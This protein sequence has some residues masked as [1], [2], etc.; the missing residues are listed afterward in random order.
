MTTKGFF[1][2][3]QRFKGMKYLYAI[4]LSRSQTRLS[5]IWDELWMQSLFEGLT[6]LHDLDLHSSDIQ[7][8]LSGMF[9]GLTSLTGLDLGLCRISHI[10]DDAF[11][12]LISLR[13]IYLDG[14]NIARLPN[15]LFHSTAQLET[16]YLQLNIL[17]YFPD[18]L[19]VSTP[20]LTD[21]SLYK[22]EFLT[23]N[24]STFIP[25]KSSLRAIDISENP[26]QC[27]CRDKWI[28][29]WLRESNVIQGEK[30]TC[31]LA[32]EN[33]FR[34]LSLLTIDPKELCET[35]ISLYWSIPFIFIA[36]LITIAIVH[37]NRWLLKY[38]MFLL[39][40]AVLGYKEMQDA[41]SHN[42]YKYDLNVMFA[43]E[44]K[45]WGRDFLVPA[46]QERLPHLRR[47]ALGDDGLM[48]GMYYLEAV[49]YTIDN[50]FKTILL[51]SMAAIHDNMFMMKFRLA[52]DH[53]TDTQVKNTVLIFLED[54]PKEKRPYRVEVYLSENM[55]HI[56]WSQ[57]ERVQRN[58]LKQLEKR[59]MV[60]LRHTDMIPSK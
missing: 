12:G 2:T 31:S 48:P 30:A 59:L 24:L 38:K 35:N 27:S 10:D 42:D 58:D 57:D 43:I 52:L 3:L 7:T 19:F 18:D 1:N 21:L 47:I 5:E 29:T 36:F 46:I 23:F 49:L 51:L 54:I 60:N 13:I 45:E 15:V 41:R 50:S 8:I 16:V 39:K 40:F 14:N 56:F 11:E 33:D 9:S 26:L 32:L 22:N 6:N 4:N 28:I 17:S 25:I 20:N 55:P 53:V 44:D 34:G 37:H